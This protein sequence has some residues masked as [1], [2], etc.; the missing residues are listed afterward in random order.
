MTNTFDKAKERARKEA[1]KKNK[2]KSDYFDVEFKLFDR[3]FKTNVMLV[4]LAVVLGT[5]AHLKDKYY[6]SL[7]WSEEKATK[8]LDRTL[9]KVLEWVEEDNAYY[10]CMN[11]NSSYF[12]DSAPI[13]FR[14]WGRKYN[15]QVVQ[16]IK[17]G[18]Q[19]EYYYKTVEIDRY[20][21]EWVKFEEYN[22]INGKKD[23]Q[24]VTGERQAKMDKNIPEF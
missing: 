12:T 10:F 23:N 14:T 22:Y 16:F 20:D 21:D 3:A 8:L 6:N 9:P 19:N 2:P 13:G 4:P 24:V 15:Y 5:I 7:E 11:W 17:N 1:E 18:Y